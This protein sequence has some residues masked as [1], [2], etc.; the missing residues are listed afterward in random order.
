MSSYD[1]YDCSMC[2]LENWV[3]VFDDSDAK[4]M[5]AIGLLIDNRD[6]CKDPI[7]VITDSIIEISNGVLRTP[8]SCFELGTPKYSVMS[9][10][11]DYYK[12]FGQFQQL[13]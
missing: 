10:M 13:N 6:V 5:K 2:T 12:D 3:C 1:N 8:N 4:S 11:I 9:Q 7:P